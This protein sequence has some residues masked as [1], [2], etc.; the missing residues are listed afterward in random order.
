MAPLATLFAMH[1]TVYARR[2]TVAVYNEVGWCG[3][4]MTRFTFDDDSMSVSNC[5]NGAAGW[6]MGF[7]KDS[8]G[9][10]LTVY[11]SSIDCDGPANHFDLGVCGFV[12]NTGAQDAD[13][14]HG[15]GLKLLS[16]DGDLG[17]TAPHLTGSFQIY[18][19]ALWCGTVMGA[20]VPIH[21]G[22]CMDLTGAP[23]TDGAT[24]V[25]FTSSDAFQYKV[26]SSGDCSGD[27]RQYQA[28]IC[29]TLPT[30]SKPWG[31]KGVKFATPALHANV[32]TTT[33]PS[34]CT[35]WSLKACVLANPGCQAECESACPDKCSGCSCGMTD[36]SRWVCDAC[37]AEC[38]CD[39]RDT[40]CPKMLV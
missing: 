6:S 40:C 3:T 11:Q 7:N 21:D 32:T 4:E 28:G 30:A 36:C 20:S 18:N 9:F 22:N 2:A 17:S 39:Q 26:F 37:L 27:Y 19:E 29:G 1:T 38:E 25:K 31:G 12:P 13:P 5:I 34:Q 10:P 33:C 23:G 16:I 35:G 15:H 24:A 14:M 8:S